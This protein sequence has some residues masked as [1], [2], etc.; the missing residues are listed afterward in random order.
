[1]FD[2]QTNSFFH[3]KS[4]ESV[5]G[6]PRTVLHLGRPGGA[7]GGAAFTSAVHAEAIHT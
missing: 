2:N 6:H 5:P 3:N 4:K 7:E 1:M